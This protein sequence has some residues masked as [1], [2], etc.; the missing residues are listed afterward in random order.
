M[1]KPVKK[2]IKK[3]VTKKVITKSK[4]LP[5]MPPKK[6]KISTADVVVLEE[7][8][9]GDKE[10]VLFFLAYL[11]HD[12]N[13]TQAYKFLHP[14]CTDHSCRVLGSRQLAKVSI[15]TILDSYGLGIETYIKKIKEGIDA[16]NVE[17]IRMTTETKGKKGQTV[18]KTSYTT[19]E[20]P[21]YAVQKSYHESLGKLLG[22]EGK[23]DD[24]PPN[25]SIQVNNLI[26][27]KK[28]KYGI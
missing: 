8:F 12:R 22:I 6:D 9:D 7:V 14:N 19:V 13:A 10:M 28:N 25:V 16:T 23:K 21:N 5:L 27:D 3:K 26:S 18:K 20:T 1:P 17:H 2:T 15:Q 4:V 24:S 11:K